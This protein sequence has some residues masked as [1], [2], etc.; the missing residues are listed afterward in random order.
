MDLEGFIRPVQDFPRKGIIFRDI[1]PLL[2]DPIA[3]EEAIQRILQHF[4]RKRIDLV[5]GIEARGFIIASPISSKLGVGFVP[6]RK[7]GKLPYKKLIFEYELEYGKDAVEIHQDAISEGDRVLLVDDLLATGGTAYA[8][9]KL[10]EKL[11]GFVAGIAFI[12]EL[13][14]LMGREK[15]KEYDLFSLIHFP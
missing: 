14:G 10:I 12:V 6:I 4:S 15:L 1:T 7:K 3:F 5:A 2:R 9:C 8:S 13:D 11:G